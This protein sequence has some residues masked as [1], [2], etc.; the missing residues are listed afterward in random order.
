MEV[1]DIWPQTLIDLGMS[2]WHPFV[3]LLSWLEQYLYKKADRIITSL[4]DAYKHIEKFVKKEKCVWIS[5]GVDLH[6]I[7]YKK[8]R[9]KENLLVSYT[10]AIGI[11]NNLKLL[12]DVA[13]K[14]Q[15][16]K[17]IVFQ[18]IGDGAEKENLLKY[19]KEKK[20]QNICIKKSVPKEEVPRILEES[21]I[22]FVALQ[23]SPLYKYGMSLNKLFD[24][25]AAGR[26]IVFSTNIEKN[27][28]TESNGGVTVEADNV[29]ILTR[30]IL[31]I[32]SLSLE[33][34]NQIGYNARKYVEKFY[35][36]DILT[37]KLENI[38]DKEVMKYNV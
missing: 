29:N 8:Q 34:R 38:L 36:I 15:D 16:K 21:D 28:I 30:A 9:K 4:P 18:I 7:S 32:Y 6:R 3:I 23:D 5:N 11:A 2:K 13:E 1:R 12:V 10:G 27:P 26:V 20:L 37:D 25:M 17:D 31:D 33:E 22:L 35:A 19:I 24:Y 14:L